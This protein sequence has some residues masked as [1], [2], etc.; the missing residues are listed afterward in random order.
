[1]HTWAE[2]N[3]SISCG[4][5]IYLYNRAD[6]L[7][8]LVGKEIIHLSHGSNTLKI[9]NMFVLV[10]KMYPFFYWVCKVARFFK[11][12]NNFPGIRHDTSH[13]HRKGGKIIGFFPFFWPTL[14]FPDMCTCII[15]LYPKKV[16]PFIK[17][18]YIAYFGVVRF[19][20]QILVA[21]IYL[22]FVQLV[23]SSH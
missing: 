17:K 20:M 13:V 5:N 10:T 21:I 12:L 6:R 9:P 8:D 4:I 7:E 18:G 16:Q 3:V 11:Q 1:M 14:F 15:I 23:L 19:A 2:N 22:L